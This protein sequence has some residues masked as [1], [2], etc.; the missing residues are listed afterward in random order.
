MP[1][2]R[3]R[4]QNGDKTITLPRSPRADRKL[5]PAIIIWSG[6]AHAE[7]WEI[8]RG[9]RQAQH[10]SDDKHQDGQGRYF[11]AEIALA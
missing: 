3:F 6:W 1:T 10:A 11:S 4:A 5:A 8:P 2:G 7:Q 9:L